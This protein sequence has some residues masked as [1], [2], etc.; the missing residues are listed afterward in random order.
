MKLN[1]KKVL[2]LTLLII[3]IF[4][5]YFFIGSAPRPSQI[6]WGVNFSQKHSRDLGL[7]WK[8]NYSALLQD[9]KIRNL[10]ILVHW[11]LIEPAP[12]K[13]DFKDLDWQIEQA[14]D[15]NAKLIL[16]IGMKVGRWPECHIPEWAKK[17][18]KKE[19]QERIL[20]LLEKIV[21]RY[22]DSKAIKYWQIENE[23][24]FY[25]GECPWYD[26]NFL[27]KEIDLV[28]LLD[29]RNRPI[30]ISDSGE[31][32][33]WIRAARYGDIVGITMY[34][35]VWVRRFKIYSSVF[36]PPVYYW[37]KSLFIQKLFGKKVICVE[38]QAEPWGPVLLYDLP[39][40]EQKKTMDFK[41]FQKNI[42][43]A[44]NTGFDEFYLWGAEWWYWLKEKHKSPEFWNEAKKL[45]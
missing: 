37:R 40:K 43:Y 41:Q 39:L 15:Y 9:L 18:T 28:R 36:L 24:F 4:A 27:K 42:R 7:E 3:L 35:K 22:R 1:F 31:Y 33:P 29:F 11:D 25:F 16:V 8:K 34:R 6:T 45:F 13:Y 26:K 14:E 17:L 5:G 12:E 10:K 19:Q 2:G 30:I 32:S 23:P 21:L 44:K 20:S 38:L